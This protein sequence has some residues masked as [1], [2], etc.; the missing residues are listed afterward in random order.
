MKLLGCQLCFIPEGSVCAKLTKV[1][2]RT[3]FS[4]L[5][6]PDIQRLMRQALRSLG[7]GCATQTDVDFVWQDVQSMV[8]RDMLTKD[9]LRADGRGLIDLRPAS[10]QVT[11]PFDSTPFQCRVL[12]RLLSS[13]M[14]SKSE[15]CVCTQCVL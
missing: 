6:Q 14:L 4:A 15:T 1:L 8:I 11:H 13:Y 9:N 10:Y 12:P 5:T 2:C 7:S 3:F